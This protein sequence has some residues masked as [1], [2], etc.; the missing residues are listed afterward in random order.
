MVSMIGIDPGQK[1]GIGLYDTLSGNKDFIEVS[2]GY[3]GFLDWADD[4]MEMLRSVDVVIVEKFTLRNNDFVANTTPL[5]IMGA[6][7][8]MDRY[9]DFRNHIVWCTPAQHKTLISNETMKRGG[10]YPPRGEVK[11]GHSTDGM[12]LICWYIVTK[13]RDRS[14]SER[15]FPKNIGG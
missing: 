3:D 1:S 8:F 10:M 9:G 4:N 2:G 11:G 6:L 15:L 7:K 14:F 12:R 13:L 5:E